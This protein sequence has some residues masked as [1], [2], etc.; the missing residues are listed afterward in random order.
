MPNTLEVE[1]DGRALAFLSQVSAPRNELGD[2]LQACLERMPGRTFALL[3]YR[4]DPVPYQADLATANLYHFSSALALRDDDALSGA[5]D[6]HVV[7]RNQHRTD[8]LRTWLSARIT[9]D[10]NAALLVHDH[11]GSN[12]VHDEI[13]AQT[14]PDWVQIIRA[15]ANDHPSVVLSAS[16]FEER[17]Q[18]VYELMDYFH[19]L[20]AV[21]GGWGGLSGTV[22]AA[23]LTAHFRTCPVL[24]VFSIAYDGDGFVC[25]EPR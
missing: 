16:R 25:W 4:A 5:G 23:E 18:D 21:V 17:F 8:V 2:A 24:A 3:P 13:I 1:L 15:D 20:G 11:V 12:T 10:P 22:P 9:T 14:V 19:I 6:L 7:H